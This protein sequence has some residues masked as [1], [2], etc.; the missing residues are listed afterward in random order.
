MPSAVSALVLNYNASVD[1]LRRC[2]GAIDAS[3]YDGLVEIVIAENG[4]T[5]NRNAAATVAAEIDRARLVDLG[6]N[7]GFAAGINRGIA[8]C[9]SDWVLILNND[10]EIDAHALSALAAT[11][12][13]Q[14]P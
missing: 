12:D 5:E 10:T 7:W 11:L 9:R 8:E 2:V 3:T 6:R 13:R 14:P 4:S 1:A